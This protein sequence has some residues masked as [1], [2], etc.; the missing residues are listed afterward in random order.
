MTLGY[1][2]EKNGQISTAGAEGCDTLLMSRLDFEV[3][4]LDIPPVADREIEGLI[5]FRLRSIYPG[6]PRETAFDYRVMRR[7]PVR[8]A[9]VFI[10]RRKTVDAYRGA[11]GRR[12]LFLPCLLLLDHAPKAGNL[13]A[14]VWHGTW[15]E[16][17]LFHNGML[18][19]SSVHRGGRGRQFMIAKAEEDLP[20][21]DRTGSVMVTAAAVDFERM[22]PADG[23]SLVPLESLARKLR[24][25]EGLFRIEKKG[26]A[27]SPW[28]RLGWLSA[29][30]ILLAILGFFRDV[31]AIEARGNRLRTLAFAM[32]NGG[33][34]NRE[35]Q[36]EVESLAAERDRR[37]ARKPG[38]VYL[39][40]SELSQ[41]LGDGVRLRS[42]L[43][44]DDSFQ[45]EAVGVNPLALMEGFRARSSFSAM[46]LSAVVPDGKSGSERFSFSGV[47]HGR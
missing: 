34:R 19:S 27:L 37:E 15:A 35:M 31:R 26:T 11:A 9:V 6:S 38:D 17:L 24:K 8:R 13:R 43:V 33:Q 18:V 5:R 25:A 10:T 12:S 47:F 39:L 46:K 45:G 36:A 32:E 2:E 41:A 29:A 21:K 28:L 44:R 4:V 7:G 14:W 20:L 16:L 1:G 40:L 23:I 22:G 42:L 3:H 30:V